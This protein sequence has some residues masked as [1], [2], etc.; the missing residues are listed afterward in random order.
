VR[1]LF[2]LRPGIESRSGGDLTQALFTKRALE[3]AG[4]IVDV[5]GTLEPDARGYDLAHVFGA[6]DPE[7][8]APQ[9]E[10]CTRAGIAT[11]LSPIWWDY[12]AFY[13]ASRGCERVLAGNP[14]RIEA[15]LELLRKADPAR[16]LRANERKKY[17]RRVAWQVALMRRADVLLPNSEIDAYHYRH[18]LGLYDR[19]IVVVH[20]ANDAP[21]AKSV[22]RRGVFCVGRIEPKKNQAMLL[23]ALAGTDV[24]LT[25]VGACYEPEYLRLC[26]R[27]MTQRVRCVEEI[28]REDV[29][30]A[31]GGAAVH[32]L[33]GWTETPGLVSMEAAAAGARIV[34]S[35]D[36]TE[37]EYYG[38][39]AE[40][41]DPTDP[42]S[43]REAVLRALAQPPRER[44]DALDRRIAAYTI[45]AVR[46]RT[47]RGYALA[48]AAKR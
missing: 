42:R 32:V 7:V 21:A 3:E 33:V 2:V 28:S 14:R 11:A 17:S 40:Y 19:P 45:E 39:D 48:L 25:L 16:F 13:G 24:D 10:A 35:N 34:V 37:S 29:L 41:A 9:M 44:P 22:P 1:V 23:Y 27:W 8:C 6:F 20:H 38:E 36:G 5:V 46:E 15:R 26:R 12:L 31:L 30:H 4:H 43:I 18:A 47:L